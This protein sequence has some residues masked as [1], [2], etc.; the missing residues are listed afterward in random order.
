M[1]S[2]EE[3]CLTVPWQQC[4]PLHPSQGTSHSVLELQRVC[5]VL[6]CSPTFVLDHVIEVVL[7]EETEILLTGSE[8]KTEHLQWSI[9]ICNWLWQ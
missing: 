2:P 5:N 8:N 3:L 4:Q 9:L 7:L 6:T 1:D